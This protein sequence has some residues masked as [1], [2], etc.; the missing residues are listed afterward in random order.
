MCRSSFILPSPGFLSTMVS[1]YLFPNPPNITQSPSICMIP[2]AKRFDYGEKLLIQIKTAFSLGRSTITCQW[3]CQERS[4]TVSNLD[5]DLQ[6]SRTRGKR[7]RVGFVSKFLQKTNRMVNFEGIIGQLSKFR[8]PKRV[9]TKLEIEN[10][11][12]LCRCRKIK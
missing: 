4:K 5:H 3:L 12:Y 10:N 11:S 7:I 6:T 1:P 2:F 8:A 9:Q